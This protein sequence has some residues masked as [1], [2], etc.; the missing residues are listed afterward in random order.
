MVGQSIFW[1]FIIKCLAVAFGTFLAAA[2]AQA[3]DCSC[4]GTGARV[5]GNSCIYPQANTTQYAS[6]SYCSTPVQS[7]P[8]SGVRSKVLSMSMIESSYLAVMNSA[9]NNSNLGSDDTG[10][11]LFM[12]NGIVSAAP[13]GASGGASH[14]GMYSAPV[15]APATVSLYGVGGGGGSVSHGSGFGINDT[16][17]L[18]APG[19][20]T[21]SFHDEGGGGGV[22]GVADM[23]RYL[24]L[25]NN[26]DLVL[27]GLFEY[28]HDN[29][30]IGP[31]TSA[32]AALTPTNSS[33][34]LDAYR[35][36]GY[37]TYNID[38][39]YLEGTGAVAFGRGSETIAVDGSTGSF[40]AISGQGDLR[41][42]DQF[43]LF[44]SI[45]QGTS[46]L[47]TK[48][49]L[50]PAVSQGYSLA[51]DVSGHLGY[52]DTRIGGFLDS[53]GFA[54][55]DSQLKYGEVGG[56]AKLFAVV[57]SNNFF[58]SPFIAGVIDQ[59]FGFQSSLNIPVQLAL[60]TG[61]T[62]Y[63]HEANTFYGAQLGL[64]VR[65]SANNWTFGVKGFV[66]ASA[67]QNSV[68]GTAYVKI[69]LWEPPPPAPRL[70][71]KY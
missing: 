59:R 51:L 31:V 63:I 32:L 19:T 37:F 17:G 61:D 33:S 26:Q 50:P 44:N 58:Y 46:G 30:G 2:S 40:N 9:I 41:L 20:T 66:Y 42:G 52:T 65:N 60:P 68:G 29:I 22:K 13:G 57:P 21:P 39:I 25:P 12:R 43:I 36:A 53:S 8:Q 10:L 64:D 48:G 16:T 49:P 27:T 15:L 1:R 45:G 14:L 47:I 11:G 28:R 24:A 4:Y 54:F 23:G 69:P 71:A 18:I 34:R 56:R 67:D 35:L 70:L 55:G 6:G 5:S 3:Q 38:K 7:S 62:T